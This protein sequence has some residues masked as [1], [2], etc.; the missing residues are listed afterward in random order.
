MVPP[1]DEHGHCVITLDALR[2]YR[3]A[4]T[5]RSKHVC[6]QD[7]LGRTIRIVAK[8]TTIQ[9]QEEGFKS[10]VVPGVKADKERQSFIENEE[11]EYRLF[12]YSR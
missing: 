4:C 7:T 5:G 1:S 11:V 8:G 10:I 12:S 2:C 3:A 6:K 9:E